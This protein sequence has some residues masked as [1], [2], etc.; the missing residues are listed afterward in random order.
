[1]ADLTASIVMA[2]RAECPLWRSMSMV[3]V[4]SWRYLLVPHQGALTG[5]RL[6]VHQC[7]TIRGPYDRL[8]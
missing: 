6:D 1:M 8:Q 4:R 2:N 3:D 7:H 5:H